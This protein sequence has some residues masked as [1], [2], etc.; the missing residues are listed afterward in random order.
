MTGPFRCEQ[1]K[2]RAQE[3]EKISSSSSDGGV[4]LTGLV[5]P[6]AAEKP[7]AAE[8]MDVDAPWQ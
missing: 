3:G 1:M 5:A 8:A 2:G 6:K 4:R 7:L